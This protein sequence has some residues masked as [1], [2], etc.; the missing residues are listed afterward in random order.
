MAVRIIPLGGL[1]EVGM[2]AMVI[3]EDGR[4]VLVDCGVLFPN[5][6]VLGVEVA[7]PDL[8]YLRE[9]GGLDAVLLTHGHEDHIGGL[10]SVLREFRVPVYGTRFT[11]G[12]LRERLVEL[13]VSAPLTEVWPGE[14]F[15]AGPFRVEPIRVTHS[16][17]DAVGF[18]LETGEGILV[19]T[20]DFKIDLTPVGGERLDIARF[21]EYGKAGVAALLSDST[22]AEREGFS[23]SESAVAEA[24][25]RR[26]G[27]ARGR[28]VVALFASNVYRVQSILDLADKLGRR[29]T[30]AGR[31]LCTN[32]RIAE[33]Q[34]LVDIPDGVLLD[35]DKAAGMPPEAL[36]VLTSGA[37]GEPNSALA[38]MATGDHR[39]LR[40]EAGDTVIF[41]SR[42]IP[43]N[44]IAVGQIAN[45][46]AKRGAVVVDRAFDPIH[47]SGHAQME[48]QKMLIDA[49]RPR[50][51]VPIHGEYR[52][53]LAHAR[54]AIRMGLSAADVF[55]IEDGEVLSIE[56]GQMRLGA[57][58]PSG[59]VWL[60]ARGG[61]D[62]SELVLRER[63]VISEQGMVL[64]LVVADRKTG[65]VV[66]G[67]DLLARGVAH[68]DEGSELHA[69]ARQNAEEELARLSA[70]MRT[71][72][73]ALEDAL[74][75]GVRAAFAHRER[76]KRPAVLPIAMLL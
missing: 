41:S 71:L 48:E 50:H 58:V 65:E 64:V 20:G 60:D 24:F 74:S 2:N 15:Q 49:V 72:A 46:L 17:P 68:F 3:E 42:A 44:E 55:V 62:V 33:T 36:I 8:R 56:S 1:G 12:L 9:A 27:E 35:V 45:R 52:M 40:V 7:I 61:L 21:A 14:R 59:R 4:R 10:P 23:V 57:P 66:R 30:L 39:H 75:R 32:V 63:E 22:N 5:D 37:Q 76:G 70:P 38:R 31:S 11:L 28:I 18:A 34:G 19:H 26:F 47:V 69:R 67:P 73:P 53:L 54:T 43:G 29:V 16:I 13:G 6:Q 51:F 25:A